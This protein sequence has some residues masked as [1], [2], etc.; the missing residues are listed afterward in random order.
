MT[1]VGWLKDIKRQSACS[2]CPENDP[3]CLDF[4]HR[5]HEEK[6]FCVGAGPNRRYS[7]ERILEEIAKCDILCA[8]CHR[9]ET[10]KDI[11]YE[12][13]VKRPRQM[14]DTINRPEARKPGRKPKPS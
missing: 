14:K 9:K 1:K 10:F 4:H 8:N 2:R 13:K 7:R 3:R 12:A 6:S 5:N 11:T